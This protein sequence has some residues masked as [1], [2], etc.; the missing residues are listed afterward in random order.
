MNKNAVLKR[1]LSLALAAVMLLGY[2]PGKTWAVDS[3]TDIQAIER[4]TGYVIVEDYDD[5]FGDNWLDK[6][7][8]PKTVKVTLAD[9][10]TVDA[11][12]TWDTTALDPRTT[13]YYFLPGEVTLPVGATNGKNLDVSITIQ[14]RKYVNLFVNG[15]FETIVRA[16][17][18]DYYPT[19]W[20]LGGVGG[21]RYADGMGRNGS[22]AAVTLTS[23]AATNSRTSYNTDGED[24]TKKV[25]ERVAAEGAGQYYFGIY[26]SKGAN[27]A[28]VTVF[29]QLM[30]RY[31]TQSSTPSNQR[32]V[33][34]TITLTEDYQ[35]SKNVV[36][37]PDDVTYM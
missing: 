23:S 2:I 30:Y 17:N 33:G 12:V 37:L 18:G 31:G 27:P 22:K 8:L 6:L 13:G 26:A 1:I 34:N 28:T 21:N 3:T 5:Y 10:S 15:N 29:T 20:Y 14:V 25:A 16:G 24:T 19:G 35:A 36:D 4:P 11:A 32:P 9:G 7:G